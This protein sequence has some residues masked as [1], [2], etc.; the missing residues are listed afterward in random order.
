MDE[1]GEVRQRDGETGRRGCTSI[2][3]VYLRGPTMVGVIP[4]NTSAL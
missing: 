3:V 4:T 2:V 1:A